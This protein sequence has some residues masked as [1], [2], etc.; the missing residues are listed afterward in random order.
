MK[1]SAAVIMG[2]IITVGLIIGIIGIGLLLG[3]FGKTG[4]IIF[5]IIILIFFFAVRNF[6][7][8]EI[9]TIS[10]T[11]ENVN[12]LT[13]NLNKEELLKGLKRENVSQEK[14]ISDIVG[15]KTVQS[16]LRAK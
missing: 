10:K 11:E 14:N 15:S 6:N 4:V 16:V 5:I 8:K 9:K 12:T 3:S 2:I 7:K 13:I 1:K